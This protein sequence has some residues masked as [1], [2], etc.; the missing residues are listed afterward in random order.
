VIKHVVKT[1]PPQALEIIF[2][3]QR[4]KSNEKITRR[5]LSFSTYKR[6]SFLFFCVN[7]FDFQTS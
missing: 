7:P 3:V 1:P 6:S 5:K 2:E 4:K